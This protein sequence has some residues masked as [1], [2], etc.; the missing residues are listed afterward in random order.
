MRLGEADERM[1]VAVAV[2]YNGDDKDLG[3]GFR[4]NDLEGLGLSI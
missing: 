3:R 1:V 4:G 2:G